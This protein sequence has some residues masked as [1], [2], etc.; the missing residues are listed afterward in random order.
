MQVAVAD[1]LKEAEHPEPLQAAEVAME[2]HPDR[3]LALEQTDL[4]IRVAV[5]AAHFQQQGLFL[6]V[7]AAPAS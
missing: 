2:A 3:I 1:Q 6:A 7:T 5:V 4:L